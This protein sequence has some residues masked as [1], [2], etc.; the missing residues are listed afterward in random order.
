MYLVTII[1]EKLIYF[2]FACLPGYARSCTQMPHFWNKWSWGLCVIP[3]WWITYS[4]NKLTHKTYLVMYLVTIIKKITR[5]F[6][7]CL[8][9]SLCPQV[10]LRR[11]HFWTT[12]SWGLWLKPILRITYGLNKLTHKTYLLM[13][14]VTIIKKKLKKNLLAY[15]VKPEVAPRCPTFK[16]NGHG[17]SVWYQ[18]YEMHMVWTSWPIK[19]IW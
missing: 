4:V 14:L 18:Y 17:A 16:I 10:A 6:R 9:T 2:D 7:C 8:L 15:Q 13:Y 12:W 19:H 1:K 3:K 5:I 11:H